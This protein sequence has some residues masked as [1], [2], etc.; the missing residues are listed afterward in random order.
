MLNT[1]HM[2]NVQDGW[3]WTMNGQ[4]LHTADGGESWI[5]RTPAGYQSGD[6]GF[7]LDALHAWLPVYLADSN[8]FGLLYTA[9]GG[10]SWVQ[11]PS[12]PPSGLHFVNT[13]DGWAVSADVGAGNVYFS[14]SQTSDGGKTWAPIP[15]MPPSLEP[16][17]PPGTIHLCNICNDAFYY[18]PSRMVIIY[19]D[20]GSMEPGGAVRMEV[21][22]DLGKTWQSLNLPL[23]QGESDALVVPNPPVFFGDGQGIL[24][25]HLLKVN[26]DGSYSMQA[27]VFYATAD[28][29]ASWSQ[30]PSVLDS[31]EWFSTIQVDP[32]GDIFIICG[33]TLC[34]SQ[35]MAR[36]WQTLGSNLNFAS[37]DTHSVSNIDFVN[38]T[39]GWVLVQENETR[40]LYQT[41]NGGL[42]WRLL[43]PI[44]V[45]AAPAT[46]TID[47]SIP[48]PTP[49]PPPG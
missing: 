40:S 10:Q 14:L 28:R 30:L 27:L 38:S 35:D 9:D 42:H 1:I 49:V 3:A 11:Y 17:L 48:T 19:G 22:F 44:L 25:I 24:P 16:G 6:F 29:G 7:F 39:T 31:T 43:S 41:T 20:L 46:V 34:T 36:S 2:L 13:L 45:P 5:D 23:P 21:S 26:Q 8:R 15:V 37:T 33:D 18:D 4:L 32:S 12:S 47:T